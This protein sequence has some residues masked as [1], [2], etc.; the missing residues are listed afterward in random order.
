MLLVGAIMQEITQKV[1]KDTMYFNHIPVFSYKINYPFFTTTCNARAGEAINN[2]YADSAK[3]AETYC[4]T[5][6]FAQAV[7][8]KRYLQTDRS[9]NSYTLDVAYTIT[10]N[11][12]CI[13]SLYTDAYLYMGGAHG[14]TKR[15]SDTWDFRTGKRLQ[16]NDI[17]PH[18]PASAYYLQASFEKQISERLNATPG[19]YFDD[20]KALLQDHFNMENY[21]IQPDRGVIYYQ[22]YDIA[23][24]STGLAEFY[25]PLNLL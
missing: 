9:W 17:Y 18:S 13:T 23:P 8:N 6:L 15:T 10:Y 14:E 4:R 21:Y 20:Y 7:N 22:Q 24:Y 25:F 3:A 11:S 16:L 19:S 2:Y 12:Q 1:L 5:V